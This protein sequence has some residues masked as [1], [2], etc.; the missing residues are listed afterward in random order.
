L[1]VF[2]TGHLPRT[3]RFLRYRLPV[4]ISV[5]HARLK[6]IVASNLIPGGQLFPERNKNVHHD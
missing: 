3:A 5:M 2:A 6:R 1:C 4:D